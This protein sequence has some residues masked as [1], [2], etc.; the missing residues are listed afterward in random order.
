MLNRKKSILLKRVSVQG[1][2]KRALPLN[3]QQLESLSILSAYLD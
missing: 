1:T 2:K 3:R